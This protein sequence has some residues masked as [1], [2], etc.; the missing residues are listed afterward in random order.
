VKFSKAPLSFK[1]PAV[2]IGIPLGS[3]YLFRNVWHAGINWLL[4]FWAL[5]P[6]IWFL[7][8]FNNDFQRLKHMTHR[9]WGA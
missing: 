6:P 1:V 9:K 2:C 8:E 7:L 4:T 3:A 5:F